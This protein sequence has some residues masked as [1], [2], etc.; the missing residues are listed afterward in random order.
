MKFTF[1][2]STA[3]FLLLIQSQAKCQDLNTITGSGFNIATGYPAQNG[4]ENTVIM[5]IQNYYDINYK[6]Q[7]VHAHGTDNYY[8]R[9]YVYGWGDYYKIWHSGNLNPFSKS[10]IETNLGGFTT[11]NGQWTAT[12]PSNNSL[13]ANYYQGINF[14]FDVNNYVSLVNGVGTNE[15][16]FGRWA[17]NWQGWNKIWHS[18]NLNRSDADFSCKN[19]YSSGNILIGKTT[20]TATGTRYKLDVEGP[21]RANEIVVNTTGADFVFEPSYQLMSLQELATYLKDNRHLPGIAPAAEMQENGVSAGEMQTKLLQK[22]EELTLYMIEQQKLIEKLRQ[23][24]D[25]LEK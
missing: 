10:N 4:P 7:F 14:G 25:E 22:V 6:W 9:R 8:L 1:I 23:R 5:G 3:V 24:L 13:G 18:G 20:Q 11:I 19:F 17:W 21:I 16:Y 15:L 12:S 2:I